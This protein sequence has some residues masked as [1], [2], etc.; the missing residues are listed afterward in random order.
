MSK[1]DQDYEHIKR[2]LILVVILVALFVAAR[3]I[4]VPKDFYQYG[5]YRGGSVAENMGRPLNYAGSLSCKNCHEER[6]LTWSKSRHQTV[7]CE[8]CHGAAFQHTADPGAVKPSKP[9]GRQFCLL[10]HAVNIS[11]PG[12]FPQVAPRGHNP[13]QNCAECH[14]P[15]DPKI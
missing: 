8:D 7:N 5:N 9:R 10:C 14:N 4:F 13:G 6:H 12:Y 3:F 2:L 1:F 11:K 15:H